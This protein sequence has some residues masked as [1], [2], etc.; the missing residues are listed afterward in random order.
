MPDVHAII[1][2]SA[3]SRWSVCA[4][5][6][7]A[8]ANEPGKDTVFTREGTLAHAVG[9]ALLKWYKAEGRMTVLDLEQPDDYAAAWAAAETVRQSIM[10][11]GL[12]YEEI[13]TIV[14]DNY[15]C[16]VMEDYFS[17]VAYGGASDVELLVEAQL[18]LDD[19]IPE[20]FGTSDAI[21]IAGDELRVYDLKYGKGVKVDA[22]GNGQMMCYA[23]GALQGP[24]EP[25]P[26][27]HVTMSIIQPRL[28]HISVYGMSS[29]A[30]IDWGYGTLKPAAELA[31]SG[32]GSYVPG[33]HCKFCRIAARCNALRRYTEY[34]MTTGAEPALLTMAELGEALKGVDIL[35]SYINAVESYA[36]GRL[37]EGEAVPGWKL[38]EGR[39]V[40]R[41]AN[42]AEAVATLVELGWDEE[43]CYKPR[44][45]RTITDL[46]CMVG[47]KNFNAI[48]GRFVEKPQGRPTLAPESDPREGYKANTAEGDFAQML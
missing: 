33:E 47:R 36:L 6:A 5:S 29:A 16:V 44:E 24:A 46:E 45:L 18:K 35:R 26:V 40:R 15:V 17:A 42:E 30:L 19:F 7:R 43:Q 12:S 31:Y 20:G 14:H 38:V 10:D 13:L 2:P 27:K 8:E 11:E 23:L 28:H 41:I 25:W 39:S 1:S 22:Q 3:F 48:L 34:L 21:I 37:M 4:P 32:K 9:E